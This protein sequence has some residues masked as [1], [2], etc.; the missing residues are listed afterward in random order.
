MDKKIKTGLE[1]EKV[2]V[3]NEIDDDKRQSTSMVAR[4]NLLQ[5]KN[6]IVVLDANILLKVYR[7]SPD[8]AEF[9]LECLDS[10]KDY[11]C[12]PFNVYWE[13]EKHRKE[14]YG[15][16]VKSIE[17]SVETCNQLISIIE[18]K[19]KGQCDELS[20]NGYPN[21]DG[22]VDNLMEKVG[23][24][25]NEFDSYFVEH[26]N[27]DF[28]NNWD[29]DRVL[30]LMNSF[31]KMPEPSA[32]FIYKLCKEGEHR[33]KSQTPPGYKDSKKDGVSKYGD[34]IIWAETYKY[35]ALNNKNIIFVTDDVKEDWWEKLDDGRILFRKELVKEFSR[36]TKIGKDLSNNLKLIPL[37]GYDLYQA[38][39]REFMIDVPDTIS[40][41]LNATDESFVDEVQMQ[42]FESVWSEIA[43]S[44]A[45]FLDKNNSH[46]GSEGV[47]EWELD[48]VEF[49]GFE[50]INVDSG[51]A[52]YII[53]YLIVISGVSYEY[54]GRDDDTKK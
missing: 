8:Y 54:W 22:L 17:K 43:Y 14:E 37:V 23:E 46:V 25:K 45:S 27:L 5:N 47:D 21:I 1:Y 20:K 42:V 38:I 6:Y 36:K 51:M 32:S 9:V 28:L 34:L 50:R 44:G 52:T 3:P 11:V 40:L 31:R 48:D 41:I 39:A 12:I 33:Y 35:A 18:N 30:N 4:K 16:K 13:Y 7:S 53:S 10:I 26:Q 24:L 49:D 2:K 29:E 15:K 19:I